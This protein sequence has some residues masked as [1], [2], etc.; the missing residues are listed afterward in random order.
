M[1]PLLFC[2]PPGEATV[3]IIPLLV[4]QWSIRPRATNAQLDFVQ[5]YRRHLLLNPTHD[6][7]ASV[8]NLV[9]GAL[10]PCVNPYLAYGSIGLLFDYFQLKTSG[11][12]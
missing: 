11:P 2:T 8:N 10:G 4:S 9:L 1:P 7:T 5:E 3:L 6:Q 12:T